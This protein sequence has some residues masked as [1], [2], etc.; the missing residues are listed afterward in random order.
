MVV[1]AFAMQKKTGKQSK[2]RR[3]LVFSFTELTVIEFFSVSRQSPPEVLSMSLLANT[4]SYSGEVVEG[5]N[6]TVVGDRKLVEWVVIAH[7]DRHML[8]AISRVVGSESNITLE[9]PQSEWDFDS[10][11]LSSAL[12]RCTCH[13]GAKRLLR[14]G[15][16]DGSQKESVVSSASGSNSG[17]LF[18]D[19]RESVLRAIASK[20]QFADLVR[21]VVQNESVGQAISRG[22][23]KLHALFYLEHCGTYLVYNPV[24]NEYRPLA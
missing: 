12:D 16:S 13:G 8:S 19:A 2:K 9:I 6:H 11:Q 24:E 3:Q 10:D 7:N 4:T 23:L 17:G 21:S 20:D 14:V 5:V 18:V 15:H 1:D 22:T